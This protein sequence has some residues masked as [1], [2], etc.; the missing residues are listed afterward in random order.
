M[1]PALPPSQPRCPRLHPDECKATAAVVRSLMLMCPRTLTLSQA[2]YL[3]SAVANMSHF[4]RFELLDRRTEATAGTRCC[5][6]A[7]YHIQGDA[8]DPTVT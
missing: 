5:P 8:I 7:I 4:Q 3:W 1:C 6:L 2:L